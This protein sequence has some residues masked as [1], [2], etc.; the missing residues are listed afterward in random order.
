MNTM[1]AKDKIT[2]QIA[3]VIH[4]LRKYK[5]ITSSQA[6]KLYGATRLSSIIFILRERGFIISTEMTYG[7]NRY[8]N[9]GPYAIY[10]LDKDINE[11]E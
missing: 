11:E 1:P 5:T 4:H 10:H 3:A 2:S 9:K 8:G 7:I 6:V